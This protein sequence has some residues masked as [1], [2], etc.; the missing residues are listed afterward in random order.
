LLY[1]ALIDFTNS[2]A[3]KLKSK[4]NP[5][6]L[7]VFIILLSFTHKLQA[8]KGLRDSSIFIP[9]LQ[10]HYSYNF[11]AGDVADF[12]NNFHAIGANVSLKLPNQLIF[13]TSFDFLF[14]ENIADESTYFTNITSS[15]GYI[16]DGNGYFAEVFL[17]GRGF[18]AQLF[19][20]YQFNV[21]SK[22]PNSGPYIQV[23]AGL[24][25]YWTRIY[26]PEKTAP[27]LN[28]E[29]SKMYDRLTNGFSTSQLLG[30]RHF[31]NRNLGSFFVGIEFTEAWT[32]NRRSYNADLTA[33]QLTGRFDLMIGLKA[34]MI[35]PFY[36][37][38]PEDYYYY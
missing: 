30:Y 8:Q 21:L 33:D 19:T 29:Y 20:G 35:I 37:K 9:S 13:G 36:P 10:A 1:F 2:Y 28:D 25:Q 27:Q 7:F 5:T 22:N 34:G 11:L 6:A 23:G 12:Y 38:A 31:S 3:L 16:V 14:T 17:Y 18:N 4:T 26:N 32:A 15:K 24:L